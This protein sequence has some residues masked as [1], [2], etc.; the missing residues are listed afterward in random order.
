MSIYILSFEVKADATYA[1]RYRTLVEKVAS[2]TAGS[3]WDETTSFIAFQSPWGLEE[4]F[5]KLYYETDLLPQ[6]KYLLIDVVS[7]KFLARH[8]KYPATL[9]AALAA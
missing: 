6:D 2:L 3:T 4:L 5:E 8:I 9:K 7:G 1:K